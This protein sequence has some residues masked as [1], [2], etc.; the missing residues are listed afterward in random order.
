VKPA[1]AGLL[2]G[3][4]WPMTGLQAGLAGLWTGLHSKNSFSYFIKI[5][6]LITI[7]VLLQI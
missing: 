7:E 3:L 5:K 4:L 6:Q 2:T 1:L